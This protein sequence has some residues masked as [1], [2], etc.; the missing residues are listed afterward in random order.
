MRR[1]KLLVPTVA[2]TLAALPASA[3]AAQIFGSGFTHKPEQTVCEALGPCTVAAF[4]ELPAEG[5]TTSAGSPISGVITKFRIQATVGETPVDVTFRVADV[6]PIEAGEGPKQATAAA[7]GTGPTVRLPSTAGEEETT[8]SVPIKTFDGRLPVVKGQHLAIDASGPLKVA[9]SPG[10]DKKSYEFAPPLIDGAS[11]RTSNEFRGEL[12]VQA[13]VEP[14]ADRDGFGDE[15]QD[16]CPGQKATQ[17]ACDRSKPAI[18]RLSVKRGKVSYRLSEP[19]T[20]QLV[21][22]RRA[23]HRFRRVGRRFFDQ[24]AKG[25]NQ[26]ALPRARSLA[27][28][29]YRLTL[30][31]TDVA[32]NRSTR[33][34]GFSIAG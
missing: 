24:G 21:L 18:S 14:D 28:G 8:G 20:V 13:T 4:V 17:G 11:P 27:P 29:A 19:A 16:R 32:G 30:T 6:N 25:S 23:H 5:Q 22:S 33:Q 1:F 10:G 15:T 34:V 2:L 7:T 26:V 31:A 12:T 9:Y 3:P